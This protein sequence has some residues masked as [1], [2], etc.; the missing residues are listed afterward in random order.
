V[1]IGMQMHCSENDMNT[2]Q[3]RGQFNT[4]LGVDVHSVI[5]ITVSGH[6]GTIRPR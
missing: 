2:H 6:G 1:L 3:K 5:V 4:D